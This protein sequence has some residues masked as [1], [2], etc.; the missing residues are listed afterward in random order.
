MVKL[1]NLDS[2]VVWLVRRIVDFL[3]S[4][5]RILQ[6]LS[7]RR[8]DQRAPVILDLINLMVDRVVA[9]IAALVLT[10]HSVVLI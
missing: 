1:L 9:R 7:E 6:T 8:V 10:G 4:I 2:L 3:T 5:L